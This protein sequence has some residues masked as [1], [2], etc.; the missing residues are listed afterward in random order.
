MCDVL[1]VSRSGFY[2]WQERP[3]SE[4]SQRHAELI[5]EMKQIHSEY[6]KDVY[7]SPRMHLE[8][9]DRGFEICEATVAKL[10]RK[11]GR[12]ASTHRRFRIRTTDSNHRLPVAENTVDREFARERANEVWVSDLTYIPTKSGWLYLVVIIDLYSRKVVGWSMDVEMTTDVFLSALQMA[13]GRRGE[14]SGLTHHSD[15]GSQYCSHAFQLALRR[16]RIDCSMSRKG[17]CW[18]NAVAESFFAT[19][20]KELVHQCEYADQEAARASV[21]EYIEVFYNRVRRHS[22]LGGLSPQQYEEQA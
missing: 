11:E 9:V 1:Q 2:A 22:F 7:G 5:S 12:A 19:L 17:N 20:K 10:M 16:N 6:R 3:A 18:D 8:L 21:F 4:R 13:L 14:V 15:R